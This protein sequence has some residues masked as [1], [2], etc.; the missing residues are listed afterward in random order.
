[1]KGLLLV[2]IVG[3]RTLLCRGIVLGIILLL[4]WY[5]GRQLQFDSGRWDDFFLSLPSH[6]VRT[7]GA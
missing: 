4:F 6:K 2:L 5:K 7:Y 3:C 1:M